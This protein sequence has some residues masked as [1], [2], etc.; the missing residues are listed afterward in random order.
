MTHPTA[1]QQRVYRDHTTSRHLLPFTV[2]IQETDL[3]ILAQTTLRDPARQS[4]LHYRYQLE[5]YIRQHPSFLHAFAPLPPDPHAPPIIREMVHA[6]K[7]SGVGPMAAV[8]GAFAEMVGL[9]LLRH[10]SEIVVENGGDIYLKVDHDITIG[11]YAGS[12]PL[13]DR[14]GLRV[15]SHQTPSGVCTSSGTVG[16]SFSFGRADAVTVLAPSAFLADAAAT[17]VC[18]CVRHS[19]DIQ[20]GLDRAREIEGVVGALII[21]DDHLGAW[22]EIELVSL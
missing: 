19:E 17:A 5:A 4:V 13:S 7:T 10:S 12:S 2:A 22:G 8:A 18:N 16:H 6:A 9:D 20:R 21:V 11:I 3:F 14:L 1:Q 15:R